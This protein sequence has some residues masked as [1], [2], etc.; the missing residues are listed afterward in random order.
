MRVKILPNTETFDT[1]PVDEPCA[2][3]GGDGYGKL[4]LMEVNAYIHQ[5]TRTMSGPPYG[6]EL[7]LS[8]SDHDGGTRYEV[9]YNFDMENEAHRRF[10]FKLEGEPPVTWDRKSY[11]ALRDRGYW[12]D[13][14]RNRES[15]RRGW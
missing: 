3:V 7:R 10:F 12:S 1:T 15:L 4:A 2:Q 5:I 13:L 14:R 9:G 6:S 11:L 8:Q